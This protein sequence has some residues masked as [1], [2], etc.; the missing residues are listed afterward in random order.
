MANQR[1]EFQKELIAFIQEEGFVWGPEPE[2]YGGLAGF[3]TYG[4]MGKLLKNKIENSVRKIFQSNSIWELEG[5]TVLPKEVWEGSGHWNAFVDK[6]IK[7][8]KCASIFRAD[9]LIEEQLEVDTAGM[10]IDDMLKYIKKLKCPSCSGDFIEKIEEESLMMKTKAG[11]RECGLRPETATVTYLPYKRFYDFF[12]KKLPLGVFQI[13]KA[14]RNE[15]SPRQMILR[16]REFTQA[17]GQIFIDPKEKDNWDKFDLVK[18]D[19]LPFLGY[20]SKKVEYISLDEAM[21]KKYMKT[22]AYAWCL[23]LAYTQF[24]SMGVPSEK[25]RLRQHH[26]DERAFYADD[27]WDVEIELRSYGWFEV[28]GVHD[29]TDYDLTTHE[30]HSKSELMAIR[31]NGEK[32]KP[33][34]LEIAFGTDRPTFALLD[35]FYDKKGKEEGKTMFKLP[36]NMAPVD[37]AILPLMKKEELVKKSTEIKEMLEKE[38]ILNYDISGSIGKRYL[39][40]AIVGTPYCITIDYDSIEKNNVTIRD[41][42]S[43][44][45]IRVPIASLKETLK[46]LFNKEIKFESAGKLVETRIKE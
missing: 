33:H 21:K 10:K 30:K 40:N 38:F 16:G 37:I 24:I 1:E 32:F 35:L 5:P 11:S 42:D 43:E 23:W 15:I 45:Q 25:I 46:K 34:V 4:P 39:R 13:G 17:E 31:E 6:I 26:P 19:K 12:R 36:Y 3:Y 27:A 20:N 22:K 28:C 2:I 44:K 9:K 41:R 8:K 7:C 14:Y 29:R 18:K